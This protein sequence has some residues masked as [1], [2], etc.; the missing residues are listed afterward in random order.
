[1]QKLQ[2]QIYFA[3]EIKPL[4][5]L[6]ELTREIDPEALSLYLKYGSIPAPFSVFRK[7]R[8][9]PP[10]CYGRVETSQISLEEY[11][12]LPAPDDSLRAAGCVDTIERLLNQA[13]SSQMMSDVPL[14]VFLSGGLDSSAIVAFASQCTSQPLKTFSIGFEGLDEQYDETKKARQVARHFGCE[15]QEFILSPKIEELLV[16]HWFVVWM[17][18]SQ[19]HRLS[20]RIL[21]RS[22]HAST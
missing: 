20:P 6:P 13:V 7:I 8:K 17:S 2:G 11:W 10:G 5:E 22:K 1:M 4:L 3:S 21:F 16:V 14:G 18:P 12:S 9:L 19:I 15:H